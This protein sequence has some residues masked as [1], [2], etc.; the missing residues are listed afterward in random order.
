MTPNLFRLPCSVIRRSRL[1]FSVIFNTV[2]G[3]FRTTNERPTLA[4]TSKDCQRIHLKP[5]SWPLTFKFSLW[6]CVIDGLFNLVYVLI[7]SDIHHLPI[8]MP[9]ADLVLGSMSTVANQVSVSMLVRKNTHILRLAMVMDDSGWG[10]ISAVA[11]RSQ[12][13]HTHKR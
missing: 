6:R 2:V 10:S 9:F 1:S 12:F 5:I 13:L 11:N 7:L 3:L 4:F 8:A